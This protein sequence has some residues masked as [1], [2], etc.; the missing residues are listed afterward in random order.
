MMEERGYY[1]MVHPGT[2]LRVV[3]LNM[4]F[5]DITNLYL[6]ANSTDPMGMVF[7]RE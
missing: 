3:G 1:S 5:M 7:I 6:L 4:Y 2:K